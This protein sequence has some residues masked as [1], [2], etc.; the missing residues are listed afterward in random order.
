MGKK[1]IH[2]AIFYG[3]F[4]FIIP[5]WFIYFSCIVIAA[6]P[7]DSH[8]DYLAIVN[9][10]GI[11]GRPEISNAKTNYEKSFQLMVEPP[12]SLSLSDIKT[13]P[14]DLPI[15]K[16]KELT[17]W[18]DDNADALMEL[19]LGSKKSYCWFDY[20]D[21]GGFMLGVYPSLDL[22]KARLMVYTI[23]ARANLRAIE[24]EFES[25]FYDILTCYRFGQHLMGPKDITEQL[26]AVA[27][28]GVATQTAL[29]ILDHKQVPIGVLTKFQKKLQSDLDPNSFTIDITFE[30][31]SICD[32]I[33][34]VYVEDAN[35]DTK[36]SDK[37][38]E[39]AND[40]PSDLIREVIQDVNEKDMKA[41]AD[42][43]NLGRT[44]TLD[45]I[46]ALFKYLKKVLTK[47]PMEL[48]EC[49]DV[50][51]RID[52]IIGKKY[53]LKQVINPYQKVFEV[54]ARAKVESEALI[55]IIAIKRYKAVMGEYPPGLETLVT[56][57]YMKKIPLDPYSNKPLRYVGSSDQF[58]LYSF[59]KDFDDDGGARSNWGQDEQGGDQ[60]FWPVKHEEDK[61]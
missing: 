17:K 10:L 32:F 7:K 38:V 12:P 61:Q 57:G 48:A 8:K 13:W 2:R 23:R 33:Q 20:Q 31:F 44:Q 35:G 51:R 18:V 28:R 47:A 40:I 59:G 36:V 22:R 26:V 11:A 24:S 30:E 52:E 9:R 53:F 42:I 43:I 45:T 29:R 41:W 21:D 46:D 16:R 49:K 19:E 39:A 15:Q 4:V 5:V 6:Q 54:A 27:I 58:K 14:E 34:R 50:D 55:T 3:G 56:S 25:A 1:L 37:F 60:V